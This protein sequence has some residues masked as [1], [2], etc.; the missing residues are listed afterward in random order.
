MT[1]TPNRQGPALGIDPG[2]LAGGMAALDGRRPL[3]IGWWSARTAFGPVAV[4]RVTADGVRTTYDASGLRD[5]LA[6]L[7]GGRWRGPVACEAVAPFRGRT[8]TAV[9]AA[10]AT[11][12]C[13]VVGGRVSR[14][15]PDVWR[16]VYAGG[17]P[18]RTSREDA[19]RLALAALH[20]RPC[21]GAP[22]L[23]VPWDAVAWPDDVP[24]HAA[25]ALGLAAWVRDATP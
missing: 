13:R 7:S 24:D 10:A 18:V 8:G 17:R 19:K 1:G 20:G 6:W 15:R 11:E 25:E 3:W 14:P 5:A 4:V 22:W 12:A 16:R 2:A 9:L 21:V 23:V